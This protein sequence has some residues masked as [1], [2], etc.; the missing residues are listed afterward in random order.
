MSETGRPLFDGKDEH[1]VVSK[2]EEGFSKG[3]TDNEASLYAGISRS[4]LNRYIDKHPA[5]GTRKEILKDQP[6]MLAKDVVVTAIGDGDKQQANWYLERKDPEFT[7][8][9]ENK[10]DT[11]LKV[12]NLSMEDAVKMS[13]EQ[14]EEIIKG[15]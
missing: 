11:T 4:A 8:K 14:L 5:F 15:K 3:F 10:Q 1:V 2:L 12:E 9:S 13:P 6:K 7:R